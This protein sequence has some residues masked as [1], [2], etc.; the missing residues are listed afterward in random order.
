MAHFPI[1]ELVQ[2]L[3]DAGKDVEVGARY[4]HYKD[5][6]KV[7]RVMSLGIIEATEEVGVVYEAQYDTRVSF[8]RPLTSFCETIDVAGVPTPRFTK[9]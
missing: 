1:E 7:Y 3:A 5:A 6:T 8:I 9:K 2:R 4:V